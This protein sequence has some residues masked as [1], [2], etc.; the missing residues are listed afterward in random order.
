MLTSDE[1]MAELAAAGAVAISGDAEMWNQRQGEIVGLS[2]I[3][4]ASE[5][6]N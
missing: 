6:V 4:K 3:F 2:C 1:A 5:R